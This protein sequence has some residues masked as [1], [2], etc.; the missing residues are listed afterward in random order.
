MNT[1]RLASRA[2]LPSSLLCALA[3][4]SVAA[5]ASTRETATLTYTGPATCPDEASFR[6]KVAR[7]L[8]YD[9]FEAEAKRFLSVTFTPKGK[10]VEALARMQRPGKPDSVRALSDT[11][12]HCDALAEA[13]ASGIATAIDPVQTAAMHN[14]SALQTPAPPTDSPTVLQT[15]PAAPPAATATPTARNDATATTRLHIT[16]D[17]GSGELV[18]HLGTSYGTGYAGGRAVSVTTFHMQRLCRLPC[19]VEVATEGNYYV[20]AP[21]M[22]AREFRVPAGTETL[23]MKVK[24][25][26]TWPV[27]LSLY[28]GVY[29]GGLAALGGGLGWVMLSKSSTPGTW[30]QYG[31]TVQAVTF[32]GSGLLVAGIVGLIVTDR[33]HVEAGDG[34]RLDARAQPARSGIGVSPQGFTF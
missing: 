23:D 4:F 33:T 17:W 7:H 11:A 32:V 1:P 16:T 14:A 18:Q 31:G 25:A 28:G 8:G 19:D 34:S 15:A 12:D 27:G 10:A 22:L 21:G 9:P 3:S 13:V 24:G 30:E 6:R 29:L 5:K 26:P 20:D 2:L